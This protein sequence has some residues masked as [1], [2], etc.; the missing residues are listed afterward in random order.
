MGSLKQHD[1]AGTDRG[2]DR[3]L[4][5]GAVRVVMC[6]HARG[7]CFFDGIAD[8]D[9]VAN[10]KINPVTRADT[11]DLA[12]CFFAKIAERQHV[13]EDDNALCFVRQTQFV[14]DF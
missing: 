3:R 6:L 10:Q 14:E 1:V 12:V 13:A 11:T 9:A 2:S 4:H 5:L 7:S 8:R